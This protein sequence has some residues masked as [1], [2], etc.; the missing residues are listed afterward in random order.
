MLPITLTQL[1]Y[2]TRQTEKKR[3][4]VEEA[5]NSR[6][7]YSARLFNEYAQ[8]L[9]QYRLAMRDYKKWVGEQ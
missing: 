8:S 5:M 4:A 1:N 2:W 9:H 6:A 3:K 7:N